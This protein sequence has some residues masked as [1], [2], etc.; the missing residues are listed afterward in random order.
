MSDETPHQG[1]LASSDLLKR[2]GESSD[3]SYEPNCKIKKT[4]ESEWNHEQ[5]KTISC[6]CGSSL[7]DEEN[8]VV[9]VKSHS[10]IPEQV[11]EDEESEPAME[12]AEHENFKLGN[13]FLSCE[14]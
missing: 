14:L 1:S 2:P 12:D 5:F 7:T 11:P 6:Q 3:S 9:M 4:D 8:I 10:P 13:N